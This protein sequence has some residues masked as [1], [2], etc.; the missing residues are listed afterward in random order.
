[1]NKKIKFAT[2]VPLIGGMT[3][4][5]IKAVGHNPEFLISWDAFS[6]NDGHLKNYLPDVP[7]YI[8]GENDSNIKTKHPKIDFVSAVCP[9]AGLS[10]LNSSRGKNEKSR[11][12]DAIQNEWLY[13][14]A[15]YVLD[16]IKPKVFFGENAPALFDSKAGLGVQSKLIEIAKKYNYSFSVYKT[17]TVLHGVPQRRPRAFYFFWETGIP[18]FEW[19]NEPIS[20]VA[21][22]LKDNINEKYTNVFPFAHD[23][24]DTYFYQFLKHLHGDNFRQIVK[25]VM[26]DKE[27]ITFWE[28]IIKI[29]KVADFIDFVKKNDYFNKSVVLKKS[30]RAKEK[31]DNGFGIWTDNIILI[32]KST[33]AMISRNTNMVHPT[34]DRYFTV[35]EYMALMG[36]PHDFEFFEDKVNIQ[37]LGQNVPV[38]TASDMTSQV[39]KYINGELKPTK[40]TYMRQNNC[41]QKLTFDK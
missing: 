25:D 9:C 19:F 22:F 30:I 28:Y 18:V 35:S 26:N 27:S 38:K 36:M 31:L 24:K 16:N 1:M 13:K 3:I 39:V 40:Y 15:D 7:F 33:P 5:N 6:K 29:N 41:T 37:I 21:T 11:G 23:V 17:N 12:A 14:S 4:G 10:M 8:I 20:D 34:E 32:N 2:I